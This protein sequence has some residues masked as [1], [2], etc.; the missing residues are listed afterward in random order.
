MSTSP[1]RGRKVQVATNQNSSRILYIVLGL[2]GIVAAAT[3]LT[4]F[5]N[6]KTG[7]ASELA[8]LEGV[9]SAP[10]SYQTGIT[11]EGF[12]YK[13]SPDAPVTVIEYADYQC[14]ACA[15]F[16]LSSL[17]ERINT[18]LIETGQVQ[19]IYHDFPLPMHPNAPTASQAA[20]CAGD[21]GQFWQ[22]HNWIYQ[23]QQTWAPLSQDGA[24][25][26]FTRIAVGLGL[27]Q[28]RFARCLADGQFEDHIGAAYQSAQAAGIPATPTFVVNGQQVPAT[29]L[30]ATIQAALAG[31]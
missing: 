9:Q 28:A 3:L 7:A 10:I 21:Q 16:A 4:I 25:N 27:D 11:P 31:Q 2:V 23:T 14:P 30:E 19:L 13:G 22:M 26:H 17:A 12:H 29:Q 18:E 6:R 1:R 8:G 20:Y 5:L 15:N 24:K